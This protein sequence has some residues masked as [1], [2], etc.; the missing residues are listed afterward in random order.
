VFVGVFDFCFKKGNWELLMMMAVLL[1]VVVSLLVMMATESS[2]RRED[3]EICCAS[4]YST[5]LPSYKDFVLR[6]IQRAPANSL[7]NIF[8]AQRIARHP[9]SLFIRPDRPHV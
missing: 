7:Q 1:V 8:S 5:R 3:D 4:Y 2:A 9:G 6:A